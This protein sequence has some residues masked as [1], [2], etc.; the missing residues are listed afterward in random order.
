MPN[1]RTACTF[2]FPFTTLPDFYWVS[3]PVSIAALPSS[4]GG[5]S[6]PP[7][8]GLRYKNTRLR[9]LS[10]WVSCVDIWHYNLSAPKRKIIPLG[11]CSA[12]GC[13]LMF[14]VNSVGA[15]WL[16]A[17]A[18]SMVPV[19]ATSPFSTFSIRT[20]PSVPVRPIY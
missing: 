15:S 13:D 10:M 18:R 7:N 5:A 11:R 17:S 19:K 6:R 1:N 8:F 12:T 9:C 16:S 4:C 2:A 20:T 3:A 14:G